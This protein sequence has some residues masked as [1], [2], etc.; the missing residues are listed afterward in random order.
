MIHAVYDH[1]KCEK[2][3]AFNSQFLQLAL[4]IYSW[5]SENKM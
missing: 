2:V 3:R 5:L 1:M 4:V